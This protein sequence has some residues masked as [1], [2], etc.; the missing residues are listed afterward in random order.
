MK[1]KPQQSPHILHTDST[2]SIMGDMLIAMICL[3]VMAF[4]YYGVRSILVG[5]TAVITCFLSQVLYLVLMGKKKEINLRDLSPIVTGL[6][7]SLM[8]PA[9]IPFS[10]VVSISMFA[11][12]VAK[13]PFGGTGENLFNPAAA[14][15]AFGAVCWSNQVFSYP[16]PFHALPVIMDNSVHLVQNPAAV[17]KLGG[18]PSY[19]F[20]EI[21]FGNVPGPMGATSILVILAC[22]I[23]LISRKTVKW[24]LPASFIGT[25]AVIAFLFPRSS[26][27]RG[28]SVL[29]EI[30]SGSLLFAA[31][32]MLGDPVTSPKRELGRILYGI[33]AGIVVM[34]ARYYGAFPQG[35]CFALLLVNSFCILFDFF[36]EKIYSMK[37]RNLREFKFTFGKALR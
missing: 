26:I 17:L 28:Q 12:L 5:L 11:I 7:I 10:I 2:T 19:N 37:R 36:S 6:I 32:F 35:I 15:L 30:C 23:F 13:A 8:L 34:L 33:A 27:S 4:Y 24:Y 22:L 9:S 25:V 21:I 18:V 16:Q 14:G 29:F 31:V 3:Y 20:S 1:L